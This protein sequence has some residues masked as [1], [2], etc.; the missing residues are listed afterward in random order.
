VG[1][2]SGVR[3]ATA[4]IRSSSIAASRDGS[5]RTYAVEKKHPKVLI[6]GALG[7]IGTELVPLLRQQYGAENVVAS[8]VRKA[9]GPV[10]DGGPFAYLDILNMADLERLVV[11]HKVD[12]LI[13]N[14]SILS[15][16]GERNPQLALEINVKGLT[17]AL[18]AAKR[19]NLRIFAPS[20][21]AAFGP[22]TPRDATPDLTI[23]R[24][25]T[26][27]GVSKLYAEL[28]G[29]YYHRRWD[30][31]FR[32]LRY[33]GV[34]SSVAPPGGGTTDYAV[35]IFYWALQ[36]GE[37]KSFLNKDSALPMMYMPDC[38]K[39]TTMLLE[40]PTEALKQRTYN[41]TAI[42]FTPEELAEAIKKRIPH[43]RITYEPDFRQAIADSWPK[44][45]DDSM[46]RKDWGW[47]HDFDLDAMVD[48]MLAKLRIKLGI[49]Q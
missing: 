14:A 4:L 19:H 11:E 12:W 21:I 26:V 41:V 27:Y 15:A 36:K 3:C 39:A 2:K 25:T 42:S 20:S 47:T 18:E 22:S 5:S 33:P 43:F 32:S 23:M 10:G 1:G 28:L 48:D 45:L 49:K 9:T 13:H 35:D 24:P 17:N 38:L 37:F 30:V 46:A 7:Q 44:S 8:D 34:L 16:A 29:D 31:D 40:A 6:T